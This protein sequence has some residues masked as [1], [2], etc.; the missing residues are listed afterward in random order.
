MKWIGTVLA[1]TFALG[2]SLY[3]K[4]RFDQLEERQ[5]TAAGPV[6]PLHPLAPPMPEPP[7]TVTPAVA[8]WHKIYVP[9]YTSVLGSS[10]RPLNLEVVL[11]LR[12]TSETDPVYFRRIDAFSADGKKVGSF[13][14]QALEL[15]VLAAVEL[16]PTLPKSESK[17]AEEAPGPISHFIV[18]WGA[19]DPGTK[20]LIESISLDAD[21]ELL[22]RRAGVEVDAGKAIAQPPLPT[23]AE[24]LVPKT[25]PGKPQTA[26]PVYV[27]VAAAHR[28]P[29]LIEK[30]PARQ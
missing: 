29:V 6:S 1:G 30:N 2:L 22:A 8:R 12:N 4:Q 20:P 24:P 28:G 25:A 18:E 26:A 3:V 5:V 17:D 19:K 9:A 11:S 14:T 15:A 21:R 23:H 10:D 13:A 7:K 16:T 27:P